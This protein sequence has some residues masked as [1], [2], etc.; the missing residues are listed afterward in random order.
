M[1][2]LLKSVLR[3]FDD[4]FKQRFTKCRCRGFMESGY[5]SRHATVFSS[6]SQVERDF[7]CWEAFALYHIR[8]DICHGVRASHKRERCDSWRVSNP[9]VQRIPSSH[10]PL[11]THPASE[12][13]SR[14]S[15]ASSRPKV[16]DC[17][18]RSSLNIVDGG[19]PTFFENWANVMSPR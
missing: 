17:S 19:R 16:M 13:L 2:G 4:Y 11:Q 18:H 12:H 6:R 3:C 8:F 5:G 10:I 7:A 15:T 1:L 9:R 14:F